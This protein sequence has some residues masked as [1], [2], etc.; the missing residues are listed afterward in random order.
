MIEDY[1]SLLAVG[2]TTNN[3]MVK[4]FLYSNPSW[5]PPVTMIP[6]LMYKAG[7][8]DEAVSTNCYRF[9]YTDPQGANAPPN[10]IS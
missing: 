5:E 3:S 6:H 9:T 10:I 4:E 1:A 2:K 7:G 8:Y